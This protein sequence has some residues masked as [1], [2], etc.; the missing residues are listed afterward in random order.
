MGIMTI[1]VTIG[2][3]I[4]FHKKAE[5]PSELAAN[6]VTN[7]P[8]TSFTLTS[9]A[10]ENG[11]SIPSRFTCDGENVNPELHIENVPEGTKTLVLFV[12][13]INISNHQV[14]QSGEIQ[15]FNLWAIQSIPSDTTILKEGVTIGVVGFNSNMKRGYTGPCPQD[16]NEHQYVFRLYAVSDYPPESFNVVTFSEIELFAKEFE[17]AHVDLVGFYKP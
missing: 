11:G 3:V 15:Q 13:D 17:I 14:S 10:F 1:L 9:P 7:T 16:T 8:M 5:A 2:V 4:A 6:P 12:F